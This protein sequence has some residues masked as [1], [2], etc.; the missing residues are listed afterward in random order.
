MTTNPERSTYLFNSCDWDIQG[1]R[2]WQGQYP[3]NLN[4]EACLQLGPRILK[5]L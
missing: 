2:Y 4:T 5:T 3:H 1:E